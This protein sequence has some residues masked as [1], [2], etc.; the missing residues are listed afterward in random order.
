MTNSEM[1]DDMIV[2]Q[3]QAGQVV[4][5]WGS[6]SIKPV[7]QIAQIF[8]RLTALVTTGNCLLCSISRVITV[9]KQRLGVAVQRQHEIKRPV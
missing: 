1:N 3:S 7:S 8:T 9:L 6:S 4:W 5:R 2:C